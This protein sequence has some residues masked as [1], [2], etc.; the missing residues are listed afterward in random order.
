MKTENT[1]TVSVIP[2]PPLSPEQLDRI[3][4][5]KQAAQER[6]AAHSAPEGMGESWRRALQKEFTKDY[7]KGVRRNCTVLLSGMNGREQRNK[8]LCICGNCADEWIW[9]EKE[10]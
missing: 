4:R 5:N 10:S 7:F 6:L 3:A 8:C 9:L 2:S 1:E